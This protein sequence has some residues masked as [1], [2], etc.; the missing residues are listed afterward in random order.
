MREADLPAAE[1]LA[2]GFHTD[3]P[4]G[5]DIAPE[6]L[7]LAPHWCFVLVLQGGF[8]GY[9]IAHPWGGPL[10]P[11]LD[12][13]VQ[14]LPESPDTLHL[15][16]VVLV[17]DARGRGHAPR[18]LRIL[19]QQAASS[20]LDRVTL[21]AVGNAAPYWRGQGFAADPDP[22]RIAFVSASYGPG[23]IPMLR[24]VPPMAAA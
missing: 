7:R 8:A 11:G 6:R 1:A 19:L 23:A 18:L 14:R 16:D 17:E 20:G 12:T 21:I 15:H 10:P 13:R 4:E 5:P 3:H 22:E 2:R 9:A 24:A